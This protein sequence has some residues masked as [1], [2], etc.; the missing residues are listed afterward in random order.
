MAGGSGR[1]EQQRGRFRIERRRRALFGLAGD[2]IVPPDVAPA[3]PRD[4]AALVA[5]DD[6]P[7]DRTALGQR[8]IGFLLQRDRPP[9]ALQEIGGEQHS[10]A[11]IL[12]PYGRCAV[13]EAGKDRHRNQA[14]L[15]AGVENHD[16]FRN[17]RHIERHAISR[18]EIEG[19]QS[20]RQ[21]VRFT[22]QFVEG[23]GADAAVFAFP[24]D[25]QQV[26]RC[27][28]GVP[29]QAVPRDIQLAAGEPARPL[30]AP[31]RV[32]HLLV[33]LEPLDGEF[34]HHLL[35][36]LFQVLLRIADEVL[37]CA[38]P[39]PLHE[40]VHIGALDELARGFPDEAGRFHHPVILGRE[41]PPCALLSASPRSAR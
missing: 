32:Q 10:G 39:Q 21:P 15:E 13:T 25:S 26:A 9:A 29:V 22:P 8:L 19:A 20:V 40:A 30:H 4:V 24:N 14:Q 28:V 27:P 6:D 41:S 5:P 34:P 35:P 3:F 2:E 38:D 7:L 18:R 17:H 36:K 37:V 11:R 23:Q 12:Q 31:R 16:D 33:W 1:V